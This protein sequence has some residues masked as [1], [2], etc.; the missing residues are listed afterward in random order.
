[1]EKIKT[2]SSCPTHFNENRAVYHKITKNTAEPDKPQTIHENIAQKIDIH[3]AVL[4]AEIQI[5]H[6]ISNPPLSTACTL[7]VFYMSHN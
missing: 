1:V 5:S 2:R 7:I 3:A 4:T 6:N